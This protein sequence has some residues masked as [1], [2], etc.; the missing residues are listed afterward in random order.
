MLK[1]IFLLLPIMSMWKRILK[2][3]FII[4][5]ATKLSS[6]KFAATKARSK[7]KEGINISICMYISLSN[8]V[9]HVCEYF[10]SRFAILFYIYTFTPEKLQD[11]EVRA[12]RIKVYIGSNNDGMYR[13]LYKK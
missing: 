6:Q 5:N 3:K 4:P 2:Y 13:T 12:Y 7:K 11:N 8:W 10:F 1:V 9:V